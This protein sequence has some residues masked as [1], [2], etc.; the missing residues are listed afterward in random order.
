M[1]HVSLVVL[2]QCIT[3][4]CTWN[5]ILMFAYLVMV[6]VGV[7]ELKPDTRNGSSRVLMFSLGI[8]CLGK[9]LISA[10]VSMK[11]TWVL[12]Q[13][14]PATKY[15]CPPLVMLVQISYVG[16]LLTM[17][18][19]L[20]KLFT[21]SGSIVFTRVW[22]VS[23]LA[24]FVSIWGTAWPAGLFLTSHKLAGFWGHL[25]AACPLLDMKA[26]PQNGQL[27]GH[28]LNCPSHLCPSSIQP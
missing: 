17:L 24:I 28:L 25:M 11:K 3:P 6:T 16:M 13:T 1:V 19:L 10:A 21:L 9:R 23:K 18:A 14:W 7:L 8:I 12:L 15:L 5:E 27:D 2:F 22:A 4:H 26:L 20:S